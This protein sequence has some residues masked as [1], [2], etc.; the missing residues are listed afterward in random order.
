MKLET[1]LQCQLL[2]ADHWLGM[3]GMITN[4][5]KYQAMILG[6][7][8]YTFSFKDNDINIPVT[9]NIDL[10]GVNI[11]KN[12]QF[13][14]HVKNICTKVN[15]EVNVISRFR[16][17]VPTAVKC[18]LYKAFIVPYFRYCSA[19]WHFC[20]ARNRDKL[21]NLNKRALSIVLDEK[22]LH[23][24][25]L[26]NKFN[27]SDLYSIRCQDM[28]KTVFK[29]IQFETM[30]KYVRG[31][32]QM[33]NTERNLRGSR[34]LVIPYV[35]TTTYVLHSFRYTTANMWNK[36]MARNRI[37]HGGRSCVLRRFCRF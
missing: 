9:D 23:Y 11:D 33:R 28:M 32:F 16:K 6:N 4:P 29:T 13:N 24:Q 37:Q 35:N 36:L 17:I 20:G 19:V 12:L 5:D 21:E 7:T 27:S 8:N 15:N 30:P 34:K 2:E 25:E 26:L 3:N 1:R 10:L 31:L 14:S 18:K 22:S